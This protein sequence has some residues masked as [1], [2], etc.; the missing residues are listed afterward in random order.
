MSGCDS[1][2]PTCGA[3]WICTPLLCYRLDTGSALR[4]FRW[5]DL[6]PFTPFDLN[7]LLILPVVAIKTQSWPLPCVALVLLL[8]T[9]PLAYFIQQINKTT[10]TLL[11]P[12]SEVGFGSEKG[13]HSEKE[14]PQ[15][16]H[17]LLKEDW[18]PHFHWMPEDSARLELARRQFAGLEELLGRKRKVD[19]KEEKRSVKSKE[20]LRKGD[21]DHGDDRGWDGARRKRER[22]RRDEWRR[23]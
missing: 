9:A 21:R 4:V 6:P 22:R 23:I 5:D 20:R 8:L 16:E 2:L 1:E 12:G 11:L 17:G 14:I 15:F 10:S 3:F 7:P 13:K 19:V 18:A